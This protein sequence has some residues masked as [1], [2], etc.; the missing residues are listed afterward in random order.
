MLWIFYALVIRL[1][2]RLILACCHIK[3][4]FACDSTGPTWHFLLLFEHD[5]KD[6]FEICLKYCFI[7]CV[8]KY[9]RYYVMK[10][11]PDEHFGLM[12]NKNIYID[13]DFDIFSRMNSCVATHDIAL[14]W[15]GHCFFLVWAEPKRHVAPEHVHSLP[16]SPSLHSCFSE[17][18][19]CQLMR[20]AWLRIAD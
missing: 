10:M 13:T 9:I 8:I 7:I 17:C 19:P 14:E 4:I 18:G 6:W 3:S 11:I 5:E 2:F 12:S 16:M 20:V 15:K 1:C